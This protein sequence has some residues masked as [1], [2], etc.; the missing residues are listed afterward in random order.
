[1]IYPS[2]VGKSGEM[3]RLTTLESVW[4]QGRLRM[5][6]RW[7]YI[8]GGSPGNMFNQLLTNNHITKTALQKAIKHLKDS[9]LSES[10]LAVYLADMINSKQKSSLA[11]CTDREGVTIDKVVADTLRDRSELIALLHQRYDGS[12]RSKKSMA[13]ELNTR[14]PDWSLRTCE[15]RIDVWLSMAE[16]MLYSPMCAAFD[17][18]AERFR[19]Q[20]CAEHAK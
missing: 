11:F 19:L 16:F 7:S 14:R 12:G 18:N 17:T 1:M 20:S 4:I 9:G 13:A 5:W 8:G 3:L 6:G 2:A 10:E 15:S